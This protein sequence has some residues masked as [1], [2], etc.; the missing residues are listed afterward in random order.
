MRLIK[1]PFGSNVLSSCLDMKFN[2]LNT[3]SPEQTLED[4]CMQ[5]WARASTAL[6]VVAR[7]EVNAQ[8]EWPSDN[9][10]FMDSIDVADQWS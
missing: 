4:T 9:T 5:G 1:C 6:R 10:F 2:V 7:Q 3:V 8:Y